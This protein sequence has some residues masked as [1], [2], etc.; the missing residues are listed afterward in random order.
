MIK[1]EPDTHSDVSRASVAT[2][3]TV[4]SDVAFGK[5]V[6]GLIRYFGDVLR[7]ARAELLKWDGNIKG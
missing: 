4:G 5:T 1:I 6:N 7:S 3:R 2:N